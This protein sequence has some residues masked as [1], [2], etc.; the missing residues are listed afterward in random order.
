VP[1]TSGIDVHFSEVAALTGDVRC[2]MKFGNRFLAQS[3]L[4][5]VIQFRRRVVFLFGQSCA[6]GAGKEPSRTS[7]L[8]WN[9]G[10][11]LAG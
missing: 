1:P 8:A 11:L 10:T 2:R 6:S 5:A 7:D 4:K 9:F 3:G